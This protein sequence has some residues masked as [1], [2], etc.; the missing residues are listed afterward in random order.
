MKT[1]IANE[2]DRARDLTIAD[3]LRKVINTTYFLKNLM[4]TD[5]IIANLDNVITFPSRLHFKRKYCRRNKITSS[6]VIK[7]ISE[8]S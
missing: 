1:I 5:D 2:K 7:L 4:I 8:V 3:D 6:N